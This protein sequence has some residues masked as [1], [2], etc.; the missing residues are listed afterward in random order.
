MV[1]PLLLDGYG[2]IN[3]HY[4]YVIL[5]LVEELARCRRRDR[6]PSR[7]TGYLP[8]TWDSRECQAAPF[9]SAWAPPAKHPFMIRYPCCS[10]SS[11]A[12]EGL[13]GLKK[14][15]SPPGRTADLFF[16]LSLFQCLRRKAYPLVLLIDVDDHSPHHVIDVE[17]LRGVLPLT[18][19]DLGEMDQSF[20]TLFNLN[21][22]AEIRDARHVALNHVAD[23]IPFEQSL[24]RVF[25]E[26]LYAQRKLLLLRVDIEHQGIHARPLS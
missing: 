11:Q 5:Y 16:L 13:R 7:S 23:V 25:L 4:R 22:Y 20:D 2:L 6:F 8:C 14:H 17:K 19:L 1:S 3:E 24:P 18:V 10:F 9:L 15:A 21:E 12:R 26:P